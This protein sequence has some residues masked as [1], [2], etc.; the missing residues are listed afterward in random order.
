MFGYI[1]MSS[2]NSV[3]VSSPDDGKKKKR[4]HPP[5]NRLTI[6]QKAWSAYETYH[7]EKHLNILDFFEKI[8][9]RIEME[10]VEEKASNG[11][12]LMEIDLPDIIHE[13][14]EKENRTDISLSQTFEELAKWGR[15][16]DLR[17]RL[18]KGGHH[19]VISFTSP[20]GSDYSDSE[21]D[22]G[23]GDDDSEY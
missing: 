17:V 4:A 15:S 21:S 2:S 5:K 7:K 11:E 12:R 1:T 20:D 16:E 10:L 14:M 8:K 22:G 19:I 6:G 23:G 13:Y 9:R 3:P 18:S